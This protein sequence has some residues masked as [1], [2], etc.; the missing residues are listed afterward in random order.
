M[1][2]QAHPWCHPPRP[3]WAENRV[4]RG[5]RRNLVD[6]A[7]HLASAIP[8]R[9]IR[10]D[11]QPVR[12]ASAQPNPQREPAAATLP[13]P[14]TP[15]TPTRRTTGGVFLWGTHHRNPAPLQRPGELSG[16]NREAAAP[17]SPAAGT[18]LADRVLEIVGNSA[19]TPRHRRLLQDWLV[20]RGESLEAIEDAEDCSSRA[21]SS[22]TAQRF[23][24][25]GR[26]TQQ[27]PE[28]PDARRG[29]RTPSSGSGDAREH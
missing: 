17:S 7:R 12:T 25:P 10:T 29:V 24:S 11:P 4:P 9:D 21:Q 26:R 20:R 2:S 6:R 22:T 27:P 16:D 3:E 15:H 1:N 14:A 18:A 13:R 23:S 19:F 8:N 28:V 5:V